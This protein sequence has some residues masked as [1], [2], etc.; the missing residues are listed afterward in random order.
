M[1]VMG[2]RQVIR[3]GG[4]AGGTVFLAGL[5]VLF[6]RGDLT[7]QTLTT[8]G[9]PGIFLVM[10]LSSTS[11]FLPGPGFAAVLAV[12]AV[13]NPFL[14]GLVAG[15]GS[16]TGELA[17]YAAGRAGSELLAPLRARRLGQWLTLVL[18][19]YG[20]VAI[21]LLAFVPNPVFDALGLLAG[22]LGYPIRPFWLACALG[23]AARYVLIA[24]LGDAALAALE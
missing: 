24:L 20:V 6:L 13:A 11:I 22:T 3:L 4:I 18:T 1:A 7:P 16:A 12:G 9:Y 17:G 19:R 21:I 8:L 2:K 23:K 14:V 10:A 15:L 5:G